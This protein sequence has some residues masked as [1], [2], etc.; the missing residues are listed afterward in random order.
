MTENN[1]FAAWMDATDAMRWI[2]FWLNVM[3]QCHTMNVLIVIF[4]TVIRDVRSTLKLW[5]SFSNIS[6]NKGLCWFCHWWAPYSG[7]CMRPPSIERFQISFSPPIC[8]MPH[9]ATIK[10]EV[11]ITMPCTN[12]VQTIAFNPPWMHF[13]YIFN[14]FTFRMNFKSKQL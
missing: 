14:V 7:T 10:I 6:I 9:I 13:E 8:D 1:L 2:Q 3:W 4:Q 11:T 12:C 5:I